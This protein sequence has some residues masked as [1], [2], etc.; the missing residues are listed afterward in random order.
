MTRNL[1]AV[2]EKCARTFQLT[3]AESEMLNE[4]IV[5]QRDAESLRRQARVEAGE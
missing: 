2:F 1:V 5:D 3:P 4:H